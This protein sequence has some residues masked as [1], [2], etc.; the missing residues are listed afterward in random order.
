MRWVLAVA[1]VVALGSVAWAQ[2]PEATTVVYV[3]DRAMPVEKLEVATRSLAEAVDRLHGEDR[4]AI[5]GAGASP[6]IEASLQS[7]TARK[8]ALLATISGI[9]WAE[10]SNLA[11]ALATASTLVGP[12]GDR[13]HVVLVTTNDSVASL[14]AA[15]RRIRSR[16]AR[17]SLVAY[18]SGNPT[19]L[20][21]LAGIGGGHAG[22]PQTPQDL[23]EALFEAAGPGFRGPDEDEPIGVVLVLD[24][25]GSMSGTK[26]EAAKEAARVVAEVLSPSD[27]LAIVTFDSESQVFVPLQRASNKMRISAEIARI[28]AGGGTNI[29]P[30]LEDAFGVL[31][32]MAARRKVV[33]LLSD[34]EAPSDGIAELV[35]DMRAARI[36]VSAVG[37]QGADRN[38][39]SMIADS[40]G[41]RL[42]MVEDL[43][44]L[45]RIFLKEIKPDIRP[46]LRRAS[47]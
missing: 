18:Q 46:E 13:R 14:E 2:S 32:G 20:D 34:G 30:G 37:L 19:Q 12:K 9:R 47:P 11:A 40:G 33:V 29:Y 1:I 7:P 17:V 3:V 23:G 42:Y 16:G 44:A 15:I 39:L 27:M 35:S 25:S 31:Q 26:L 38:L 28:T 4:V 24:R 36:T 5:V 41:G 10:R 21:Y 22:I 45:P 8:K 6:S 43:G